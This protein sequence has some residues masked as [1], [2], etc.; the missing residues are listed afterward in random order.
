MGVRVCWLQALRIFRADSK[1][2]RKPGKGQD[3]AH[4][5][6]VELDAC[7][8]AES[9]IPH[10]LDFGLKF[11]KSEQLAHANIRNGAIGDQPTK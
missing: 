7:V 8:N 3:E 1:R 10:N 9:V 11:D 6:S 4:R 2:R 5:D